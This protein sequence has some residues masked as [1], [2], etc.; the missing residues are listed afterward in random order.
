MLCPSLLK[1]GDGDGKSI[2]SYLLLVSNR[3]PTDK[4]L[5]HSPAIFIREGQ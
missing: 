1:C 5:S 4:T 2:E 3:Q